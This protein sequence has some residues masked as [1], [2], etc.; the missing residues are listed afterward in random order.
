M[1]EMT[2]IYRT[3]TKNEACVCTNIN[4]WAYTDIDKVKTWKKIKKRGNENL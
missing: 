1:R 2:E 3:D 4:C